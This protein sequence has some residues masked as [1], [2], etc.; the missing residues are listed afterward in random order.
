MRSTK[1]PEQ[2]QVQSE[3]KPGYFYILLK[4]HKHGNPGRRIVSSNGHPTERI[5]EFVDF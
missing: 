1:S 4:I 2:G 3:P 5:S